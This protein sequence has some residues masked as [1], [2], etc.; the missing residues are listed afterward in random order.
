MAR[1]ILELKFVDAIT[2]IHEAQLLTCLKMMRI[3]TG[4]L[5]NFNACRLIGGIKRFRL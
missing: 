3:Q 1:L 5:I 4:L 2:G